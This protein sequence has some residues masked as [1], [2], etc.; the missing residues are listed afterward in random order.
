LLNNLWDWRAGEGERERER[1]R[2]GRKEG[3]KKIAC[4]VKFVC[5]SAEKHHNDV[6]VGR[7]V[8]IM[9]EVLLTYARFMNGESERVL[10]RTDVRSFTFQG[11]KG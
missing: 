9:D 11:S 2:R 1:M 7:N 4:E 10:Q 3:K 8:S 6:T 5:G